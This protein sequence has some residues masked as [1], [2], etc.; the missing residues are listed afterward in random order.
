MGLAEI[1]HL[2]VLQRGWISTCW[3]AMAPG[4]KISMACLSWATVKLETPISPGQALALASASC[5]R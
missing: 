5:S 4:P 1:D 3:W 2:A